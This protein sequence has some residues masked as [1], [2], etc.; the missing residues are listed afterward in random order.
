VQVADVFEDLLRLDVPAH[1]GTL[2]RRGYPRITPI[3]FLFE[4]GTFYMTSLVGKRH[5]DDLRRDPRASIRIDVEEHVAVS[6]VR[7]NRQVGGRGIAEL[8][9]DV[10]GGWTR[11]ITLKYVSGPEGAARATLRAS[12]ERIAIVLRPVRL[13]R[14]RT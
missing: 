7:A 13:E 9:P 2:D 1:L 6:G 8:R 11:R 5:V 4:D 12:Q 14:L 10:G 3:W